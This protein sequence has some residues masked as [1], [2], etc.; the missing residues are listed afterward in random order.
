MRDEEL[1]MRS[2][3]RVKNESEVV[4]YTCIV[5]VL[6]NVSKRFD[7]PKLVTDTICVN[8][9]L[10]ATTL[11]NYCYQSMFLNCSNLTA[12]PELPATTLAAACYYSMFQDCTKLMVST[13][14]TELYVYAW[15]IP[16]SGTIGTQTGISNMLLNTGGTFTGNPAINTTYYVQAA[17]VQ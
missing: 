7:T 17:P 16:A 4:L 15:R 3:A 11:A 13:T 6:E 5:C 8:S 12:V 2:V 9:A 10:P 14:Q 1:G